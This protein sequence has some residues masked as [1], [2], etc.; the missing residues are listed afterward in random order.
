MEE[1]ER[2][3]DRVAIIHLGKI[4]ALGSPRELIAGLQA[5]HIVEFSLSGNGDARPSHDD[6]L[7]LPAV[8]GSTCE[9]G[10]YRLSVTQPHVVIPAVLERLGHSGLQ[11]TSLTTRHASLEDVFVELTGRHLGDDAEDADS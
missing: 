1:A 5:E 10:C 8:R 7:S 6:W 3:C 4:I 11:L 2:L 9:N